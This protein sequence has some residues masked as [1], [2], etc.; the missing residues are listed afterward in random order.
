MEPFSVG[1][2]RFKIVLKRDDLLGDGCT[3]FCFRSKND[4]DRFRYALMNLSEGRRWDEGK[5]VPV[6]T[7]D[8]EVEWMFGDLWSGIAKSNPLRWS[9]GTA[10]AM[11]LELKKDF[12]ANQT[13]RPIDLRLLS[14]VS[15]QEVIRFDDQAAAREW[16]ALQQ[17]PEG[18]PPR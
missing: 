16:L 7:V 1:P 14:A 10:S 5:V 3:R 18:V 15:E 4:R 17:V 6:P 13:A 8:P 12:D 11:A 2:K 9:S